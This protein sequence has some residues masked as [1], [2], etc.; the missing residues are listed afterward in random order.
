MEFL[1]PKENETKIEVV[2]AAPEVKE[3]SPEDVGYCF[4]CKAKKKISNGAKQQKTGSRGTRNW[5]IGT[6]PDCGTIIMRVL[7]GK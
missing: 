6:C 3:V 1:I 7:K 5:F 2:A 4:K